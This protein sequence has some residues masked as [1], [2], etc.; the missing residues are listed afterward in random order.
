M[1]PRIVLVVEDDAALR[2][3]I[4]EV[5]EEEGY[6]A[7]GAADGS[8][9]LAYLRDHGP[10]CMILLDLMMPRLNGW[11]FRAEQEQD[12]RI[13]GVCT[14]IM[15]A[16]SNLVTRPLDAQHFLPKPIRLADLL[17][18]VAECCAA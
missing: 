5:L 4:C 8:E 12:P 9:A 16:A 13:A 18:V 6:S 17:D 1:N 10:P 11:E 7:V 14:T 3:S 15:T 2:Q